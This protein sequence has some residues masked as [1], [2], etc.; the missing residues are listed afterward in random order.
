MDVDADDGV[1][2]SV[3]CDEG[4]YAIHLFKDFSDDDACKLTWNGQSN[5]APTISTVLLQIYNYNT[6]GWET[7][8]S[9]N[10]AEADVDFTLSAEI[11]DTA[12]YLSGNILTCRVYQQG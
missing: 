5:L 4:D 9:N 3:T 11:A 1:R 7:V 10:T 6:P 8:D 2:V 12:N